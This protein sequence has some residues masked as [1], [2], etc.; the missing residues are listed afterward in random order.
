MKRSLFLCV[1]N[2]GSSSFRPRQSPNRIFISSSYN[3]NFSSS[4][5]TSCS[6]SVEALDEAR[7]LAH[8]FDPKIPLQEAL[9]PPSSW[10][11]HPC[12]LSLEFDRV[13]FRGWQA[14]GIYFYSPSLPEY[15][16]LF[17]L[18]LLLCLFGCL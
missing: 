12:F 13:F 15:V 1:N 4:S 3:P 17:I 2:L 11:T 7:R 9:T 6:S 16:F 10:Y 8:Q 18:F 5:S 14:V